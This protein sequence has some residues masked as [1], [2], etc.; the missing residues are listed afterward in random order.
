MY[1]IASTNTTNSTKTN[2][3]FMDADTDKDDLPTSTQ[4]G[5]DQGDGVS[6]MKTGKGSMAISLESLNVFALNSS[7]EW[8]LAGDK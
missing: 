1:W 4:L 7:D 2:N 3:Y 5:K 6:H 8:I